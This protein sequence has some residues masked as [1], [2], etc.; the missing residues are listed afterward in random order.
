M[1]QMR[2]GTALGLA[3]ACGAAAV[4]RADVYEA[5]RLVSVNE[6]EQA[7]RAEHPAI[8][9]DGRY[10]AFDGSFGGVSGVWRKDLASGAV[11]AVAV[12]AEH[13]PIGESKL[14]SLSA[15][16]R[17]VSF[18]TTA[19]LDEQNDTNNGPDVYERDM[20]VAGA[21]V[22]AAGAQR[23]YAAALHRGAGRAPADDAGGHA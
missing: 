21:C 8:S 19:R 18:T 15:D 4:A 3:L 22:L 12:G 2:L 13:T 10:V 7:D 5:I 20:A 14:P 23:Q 1:R 17:Y 16:G 6:S 11:Q 9:L